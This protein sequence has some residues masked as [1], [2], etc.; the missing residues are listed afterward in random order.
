MNSKVMSY[1]GRKARLE[2]VVGVDEQRRARA[3]A[4]PGPRLD[5]KSGRRACVSTPPPRPP[6]YRADIASEP[7]P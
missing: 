5:A 4:G 6:P 1:E 2:L 7:Q 3:A